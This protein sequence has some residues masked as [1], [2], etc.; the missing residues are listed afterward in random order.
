MWRRGGNIRYW[1]ESRPTTSTPVLVETSTDVPWVRSEFWREHRRMPK[2][3]SAGLRYRAVRLVGDRRARA[4]WI[5]AIAPELGVAGIG[6]PSIHG[7]LR[8]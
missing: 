4:E 5:R 3:S 7:E 8:R 1:S 6:T 2:S